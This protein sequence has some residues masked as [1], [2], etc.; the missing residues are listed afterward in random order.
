MTEVIRELS[1]GER[2]KWGD[3]P[4]CEAKHGQPCDPNVGIH[5]GKTASG[6]PI[7]EGVHSGRLMQAP[8]RVRE[9]PL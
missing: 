4:V 9:V 7:E 5:F 1:I 2:M 6:R 3:C 8:I